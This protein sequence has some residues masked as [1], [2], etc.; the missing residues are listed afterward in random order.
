MA[1]TSR[2]SKRLFLADMLMNGFSSSDVM[3]LCCKERVGYRLLIMAY[4]VVD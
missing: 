4:A 3:M 2:P 1:A